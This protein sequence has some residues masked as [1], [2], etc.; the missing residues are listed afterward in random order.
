MPGKIV[1]LSPEMAATL[2]RLAKD[3]EGTFQEIADEAFR[4]V[5]T[6]YNRPTTLLSALRE[7]VKHPEVNYGR[8]QANRRQR[9]KKRRGAKADAA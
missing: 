7:S 4:D 3:R 5:L 9:P 6:K 1:K 8:K 2:E